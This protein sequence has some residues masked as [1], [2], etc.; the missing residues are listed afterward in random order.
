MALVS[1]SS[2]TTT[3]IGGAARRAG[4]PVATIRYYEE[5]GI[6]PIAERG[7]GGQ[8]VYDDVAIARLTFIRRCRDL[9]M[10]I[11]KITA[12]L[13]ISDD[14]AR[15]CADAL[16]LTNEHLE[17][18]RSRIRELTDLEQTLSAFAAECSSTCC[19]GPSVSCTLFSEMRGPAS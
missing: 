6:M 3:T 1:R 19:R 18:V 17:V 15:P 14:G 16:T 9:D 13:T 2:T 7:M 4:C 8:R 11:E 12:L 5:I 10:P